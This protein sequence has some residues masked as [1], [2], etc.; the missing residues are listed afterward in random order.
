NNEAE[1]LNLLQAKNWEDFNDGRDACTAI[2][3]AH[4]A[5]EAELAQKQSEADSDPTEPT[6][7][8]ADRDRLS[9]HLR[10]WFDKSLDDVFQSV[11]ED[12]FPHDLPIFFENADQA[13]AKINQ[14]ATQH[15]WDL[16][17]TQFK[18]VKAQNGCNLIFDT[19][20]GKILCFSRKKFAG[21]VGEEFETMNE[22]DIATLEPGDY[23]TSHICLAWKQVKVNKT[24]TSAVAFDPYTAI[25][26]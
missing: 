1:L 2:K 25:P 12:D 6:W 7:T 20:V 17:V 18:V 14:V 22:I 13:I 26:I 21:F 15:Q 5:L 8:S 19:P 23:E 10:R 9:A 16:I 4:E 3:A 11:D 24:V